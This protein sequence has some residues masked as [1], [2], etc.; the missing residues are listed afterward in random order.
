MGIG[1]AT[2][3]QEQTYRIKK[4]TEEDEEEKDIAMRIRAGAPMTRT[5]E[6]LIGDGTTR[7]DDVTR[8]KPDNKGG[9][10]DHPMIHLAL[11][12]PL[13]IPPLQRENEGHVAA[14]PGPRAAKAAMTTVLTGIKTTIGVVEALTVGE[15]GEGTI[16]EAGAE[17][18]AHVARTGDKEETTAGRKA[19][20][21]ATM[22]A[23]TKT[24]G[25]RTPPQT[26]MPS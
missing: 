12:P 1:V 21:K 9:T 19:G 14:K 8:E 4:A 17:A 15:Q 13:P 20:I 6:T 2:I 24:T 3:A 11:L 25:M 10:M 7:K 18:E 22:K 5:G 16:A 26:S 23:I